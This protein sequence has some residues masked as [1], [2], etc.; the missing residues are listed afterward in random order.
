M[1]VKLN[2]V[3]Q[4]GCRTKIIDFQAGRDGSSST[5]PPGGSIYGKT[6]GDITDL[7]A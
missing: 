6:R 7:E 2:Q 5:E 1:S 4:P 3:V